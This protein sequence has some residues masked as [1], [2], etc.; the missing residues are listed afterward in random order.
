ML[1]LLRWISDGTD[2]KAEICPSY[3]GKGIMW[4]EP[5]LSILQN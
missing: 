5:D 3:K 2:P 1:G 4:P